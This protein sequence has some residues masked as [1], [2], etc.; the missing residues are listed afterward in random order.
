MTT[1]ITLTKLELQKIYDFVSKNCSPDENVE[2]TISNSVN[3]GIGTAVI[4]EILSS[5][6]E[7]PKIIDVTDYA[8]W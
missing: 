5:G 7:P 3:S 4:V 6:S 8:K 2:I 1:K